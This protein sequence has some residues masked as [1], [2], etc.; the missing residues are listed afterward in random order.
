MF[1]RVEVRYEARSR[2][3]Q[4]YRFL[5]LSERETANSVE[6]LNA[7][8]GRAE[9]AEE[10]SEGRLSDTVVGEELRG[11]SP[12]LDQRW[13]GALFALHPRNP[14]AARHFCTSAREV[15]TKFLELK[16]PDSEVLKAFPSCDRAPDGRPTRRMRIRLMLTRKSMGASEYE[17]FVAHDVENI[18]ELF[19]VFNDGTHGTAGKYSFVQLRAVKKRV[20]DGI[21]FLASLVQ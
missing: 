13:R 16:A 10:Q 19:K 14:D 21:L 15:F 12:E 8:D 2:S 5:D 6:V 18:I 20:E 7:L 17:D 4:E 1:T 11:V 3:D 9:G